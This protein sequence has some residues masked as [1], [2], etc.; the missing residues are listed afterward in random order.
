MKNIKYYAGIMLLA[1]SMA[2]TG[3]SSDEE[4]EYAQ[5]SAID[6][7]FIG[8]SDV[9]FAETM[10]EKSLELYDQELRNRLNEAIGS[11]EALDNEDF[12][13]IEY[14]VITWNEKTQGYEIDCTGGE[15]TFFMRFTE[16]NIYL[17]D[18]VLSKTNCKSVYVQFVNNDK[19]LGA[20]THS[21]NITTLSIKNSKLESLDKLKKFQNLNLLSIENCPNINDLTPLEDLSNLEQIV[22]IGTKVSDVTP[23][24]KIPTIT[25]L[26]LRCNEITNPEVLS[27]LENL[28]YINLVYNKIDDVKKLDCFVDKGLL[29]PEEAEDIVTTTENHDI[30]YKT[31]DYKERGSVLSITYYDAQDEYFMDLRDSD[32]N[33]V[34]YMFVKEP[35]N[36]YSITTDLENCV[37]LRLVNCPDTNIVSNICKKDNFEIMNIDHCKFDSLYF[38]SNFE[39]LT[40]LGVES[41]L[42]VEKDF[43]KYGIFGMMHLDKLKNVSIKNTNIPS[44]DSLSKSDSIEKVEIKNNEIDD[45]SFLTNLPN[46]TL[47]ILTIDGNTV[48]YQSF[49][50]L[51]GNDVNL[52]VNGINVT[53]EILENS[54]EMASRLKR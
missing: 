3:C 14:V 20:F 24:S 49:K 31:E 5:V 1:G 33:N 7:G 43:E 27:S 42:N 37:G 28:D 41:C 47:A 11:T 22:L 35:F 48:D 16:D 12:K 26:N 34:A 44:L 53:I 52:K 6:S 2:L 39:N 10:L 23:L 40:S 32:F 9:S 45:Y 17:I 30:I 15:T 54:I 13:K 46:L 29:K 4:F 50:E 8:D 19:I 38:V 36:V 18:Y 21:N 51:L 25:F